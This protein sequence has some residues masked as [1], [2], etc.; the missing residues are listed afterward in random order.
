MCLSDFPSP[1][2]SE[3]ALTD[4]NY[5]DNKV[6]A[7]WTYYCCS[8][9]NQ[10]LHD[11]SKEIPCSAGGPLQGQWEM[12]WWL[13][14]GEW[15]LYVGHVLLP[16]WCYQ[17]TI[18]SV[19]VVPHNH[20]YTCAPLHLLWCIYSIACRKTAFVTLFSLHLFLNKRMQEMLDSGNVLTKSFSGKLFFF[21]F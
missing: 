13:C 18:K 7:L 21:F 6:Q 16:S 4:R 8:H 12:S 19:L 2:L 11:D 14:S 5:L 3:E 20:P 9:I 15:C 10:Q 1:V 17:L